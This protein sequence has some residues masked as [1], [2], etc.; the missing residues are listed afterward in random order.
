MRKVLDAALGM[1]PKPIDD[2]ICARTSAATAEGRKRCA[3][4]QA[5]SERR[6]QSTAGQQIGAE[7][8]IVRQ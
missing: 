2:C 1:P 3:P 5:R 6:R 4:G 8:L 7:W